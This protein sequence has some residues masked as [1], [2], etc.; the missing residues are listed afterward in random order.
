MTL[1]RRVI[2]YSLAAVLLLIPALLMRA[3][4]KEPE[5]LNR[6]DLAILRVSSPLQ[7]VVT[8]AV[9]GLGGLWTG[10][11]WL[12]DVD[13]E[14]GE[15][16]R[17]NARLR[18]QLAAAKRNQISTAALER[19]VGLRKRTTADTMGARVI[20][21]SINPYFRV[22]RLRLDR[23]DGE[24]EVGMPI[25]N[26]DGLVGR[27]HHVYGRYSDVLLAT[28]PQSS[29]DVYVV[30]F[31]ADEVDTEDA[32]DD[33]TEDTDTEA[34]ADARAVPQKKMPRTLQRG[35]YRVLGRGVLR[36]LSKDNSYTSEIEYL[37][38]GEEVK[39][40]DLVVTSG[41]GSAFPEGIP[42]GQISKV[43]RSQAG[44]FQKVDVLPVVDFG[45]LK[46]VLVLLA[47]PPP[48]DP[49]PG[50]RPRAKRA[51]GVRPY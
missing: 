10:Y 49:S 23:G 28:D 18:K 32:D 26:A 29:I 20:S 12:V 3:S 7:S 46:H 42:I 1:R 31:A 48:P 4:F 45:E 6:L 22:L 9:E 24:V 34:G 8:W 14:N 47:P 13:E 11:V 51:F 17:E 37:E 19:L 36:G 38:R 16:R 50:K 30:R 2:D 35:K 39:E 25:V 41:L 15:L 44:L 33:A 5:H 27:V 40:G 43:K 21:A